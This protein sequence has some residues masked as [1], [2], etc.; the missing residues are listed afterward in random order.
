ML[1]NIVYK[2]FYKK[3]LKK[4]RIVPITKFFIYENYI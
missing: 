2:C 4:Y 1:I 3:Y